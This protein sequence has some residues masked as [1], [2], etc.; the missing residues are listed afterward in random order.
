MMT[1]R[2]YN[3]A[4]ASLEINVVQVFNKQTRLGTN[5]ENNYNKLYILLFLYCS[6]ILL[7]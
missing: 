6:A 5:L 1:S 7:F 3:P 2:M 4:K